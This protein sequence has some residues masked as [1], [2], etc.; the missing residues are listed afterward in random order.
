MLLGLAIGDAMGAPFEGGPGERL[1][2]AII[3]R[4]RRGKRR[5]TDDTQMALDLVD[6]HL[7]C[8]GV[9]RDDLARTF[10]ASYRW[11]R[12][13]GPGTAEVLRRIRRGEPW[14]SANRG[15]Y[16]EGSFGNGAAM[17]APVAALLTAAAP[18]RLVEVVRATAEVTHGHET[19]VQGAIL[20]AAATAA[21]LRGAEAAALLQHAATPVTD[22]RLQSRLAIAQRWLEGGTYPGQ[23]AVRA[24]LGAKTT[25]PESCVTAVFLGVQS[26]DRPLHELL[27]RVR[28]V[29]GDV[30]TI[31]AMA[32]A[33]WGA[34]NGAT[35]IPEDYL[36]RLEQRHRLYAA[37][38]ALWERVGASS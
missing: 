35:Q 37:A 36:H 13:Y 31:G 9:D 20:V 11:H 19:A 17:R 2:W 15:V 10:A 5:W 4:D 1:V 21:A 32:A 38:D 18:G 33:I 28:R 6:S 29:G 34:H 22:R 16:P 7:R 24:E 8:G 25:A 14:R 27:H 12:G 26:L 30:D 3:G 23:R